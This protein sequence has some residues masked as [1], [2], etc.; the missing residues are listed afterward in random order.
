ME[1]WWFESVLFFVGGDVQEVVHPAVRR[2]LDDVS[3]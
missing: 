1:G 3:L 2:F